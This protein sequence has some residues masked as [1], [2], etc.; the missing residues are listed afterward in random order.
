MKESMENKRGTN[1][2]TTSENK[3]ETKLIDDDGGKNRGTRKKGR[4]RT[5]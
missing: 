4:P 1:Q 5:K 2:E 3:N